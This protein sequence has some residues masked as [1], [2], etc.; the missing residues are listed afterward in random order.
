MSQIKSEKHMSQVKSEKQMSQEKSENMSQI[1][2]YPM[3]ASTKSSRF[4]SPGN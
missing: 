4:T 2:F 3:S 1:A